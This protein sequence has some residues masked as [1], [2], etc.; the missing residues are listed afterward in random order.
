MYVT[1]CRF[2]LLRAAAAA[3]VVTLM[4]LFV[5]RRLKQSEPIR[6][7][8]Q[9]VEARASSIPNAGDGLYAT[10]HFSKGEVLG[11]Y[12]GRVLTLY[13]AT[14]LENRDYL[15][16]GFGIN[17]HVDARFALGSAARYVNDH[18]DSAKRNAHF[19]KDKRAKR[20]KLVAMRPIARGEEVYAS[21]GES[22][23]RARGIE[24][25]AGAPAS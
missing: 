9:G 6:C 22:Y 12:H 23:W 2:S 4:L 19:I 3:S 11:E 14:R 18:F 15:M 25:Q 1:P 8:P 13:Q 17:A 20:A 21:Y 10:R 16:G 7:W 5:R 24:Y